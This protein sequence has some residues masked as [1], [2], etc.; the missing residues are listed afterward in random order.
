MTLWKQYVQH[1]MYNI[2]HTVKNKLIHLYDEGALA[3]I[4]FIRIIFYDINSLNFFSAQFCLKNILLH[5]I[6]ILVQQARH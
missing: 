4:N 5:N 3:L 6:S 2:V 1:N